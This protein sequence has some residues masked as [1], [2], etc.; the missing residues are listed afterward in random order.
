MGERRRRTKKTRTPLTPS[1]P[2]L[3]AVITALEGARYIKNEI[4]VPATGTTLPRRTPGIV[5]ESGRGCRGGDLS[6]FKDFAVEEVEERRSR[7]RL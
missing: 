7:S 2:R 3:R 4:I 6:L 5:E 1:A